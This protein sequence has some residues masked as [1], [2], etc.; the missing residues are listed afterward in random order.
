M[1]L[2]DFIS[3]LNHKRLDIR[4]AKKLQERKWRLKSFGKHAVALYVEAKHGNFIVNPADAGVAKSLLQTGSYGDHE[5][6]LAKGFINKDSVCVVLG[7]HIGSIAVPF[8]KLSN[9]VHVFEANPETFKYLSNNVLLNA[10]SNIKLYNFAVSDEV[11]EISFIMQEAN[12]GSSRRK[13]IHAFEPVSYETGREI[14]VKTLVLDDVFQDLAPDLIF[15]DIEG[16]EYFALRGAQKLLKRTKALIMEFNSEFFKRVSNR[17]SLEVCNLFYPHFDRLVNPEK[18]I[19]VDGV[20]EVKAEIFRM[21][22]NKEIY[23]NILFEKSQ[24]FNF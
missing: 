4:N 11:G 1:F 5:I 14:K 8:S 3:R 15:M 12:S 9:S 23:E 10:C 24:N 6:E 21:L 17:S 16:S 20:D 2:I 13:P 22:E 19:S 7:G 18:M